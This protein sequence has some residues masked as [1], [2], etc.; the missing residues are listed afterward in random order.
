MTTYAEPATE[1]DDIECGACGTTILEAD[2]AVC[3]H[4]A[5]VKE[6]SD[7]E[8]TLDSTY[9][10]YC[11]DCRRDEVDV[12]REFVERMDHVSSLRSDW[13]WQRVAAQVVS[14]LRGKSRPTIYR[15]DGR[16]VSKED[17]D[18]ANAYR[19]IGSLRGLVLIESARAAASRLS[20]EEQ[21]VAS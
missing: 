7:C 19:R 5:E 9:K 13:N 8:D 2:E 12:A 16:D 20:A 11:R 17:Y 14:D 1:V 4:C 10:V 6:C 21:E 3:W 18:V 15:V